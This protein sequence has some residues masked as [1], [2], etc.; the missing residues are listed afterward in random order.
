M[1][2]TQSKRTSGYI[3]TLHQIIFFNRIFSLFVVIFVNCICFF[4]LIFIGF[5]N[6]NVC[7]V[8]L[9]IYFI[10][11]YVALVSYLFTQ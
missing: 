10:C 11:L 3:G 7:C 8:C 5:S 1:V 4:Y 2:T 9:L 6:L